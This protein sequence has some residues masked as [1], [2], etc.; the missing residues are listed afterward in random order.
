MLTRRLQRS[1]QRLSGFPF[2]SVLIDVSRVCHMP[3][4]IGAGEGDDDDDDDDADDDAGDTSGAASPGTHLDSLRIFRS[5]Y[6]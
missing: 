4:P 1:V 3:L 5:F 2:S 6:G